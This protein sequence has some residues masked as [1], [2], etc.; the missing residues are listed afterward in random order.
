MQQ[1]YQRSNSASALADGVPAKRK[2]TLPLPIM[3]TARRVPMQELNV[4]AESV[5]RVTAAVADG[6]PQYKRP[7]RRA[8]S[9]HEHIALDDD[10]AE[11]AVSV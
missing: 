3:L 10:T 8:S 5:R 1:L 9:A 6:L 7:R 11:A 2:L 4:N